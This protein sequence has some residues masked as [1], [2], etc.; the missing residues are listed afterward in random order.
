MVCGTGYWTSLLRVPRPLDSQ[1]LHVL[2]GCQDREVDALAE[3]IGLPTPQCRVS[4]TPALRV[5]AKELGKV[6]PW[7]R[8][9]VVARYKGAKRLRY[10]NAAATLDIRPLDSRDYKL[11]AFVKKEK[12]DEVKCPRLIQAR[13]ERYNIEFARYF[14]PIEHR[15][16]Q[17]EGGVFVGRPVLKGRNLVQRAE[18]IQQHWNE[19]NF[20]YCFDISKMD[21]SYTNNMFHML[22]KLYLK[23][24]RDPYFKRM[25]GKRRVSRG[26][27]VNGVRYKIYNKR[28]SGDIDTGGGNTLAV[29]LILMDFYR[30]VGERV[31]VSIDGD[32]GAAYFKQP[33]ITPELLVHQFKRFGF[34]LKIS[35][36]VTDIRDLVLCQHKVALYPKPHM[37]RNP[38]KALSQDLANV[39]YL[40]TEVDRRDWLYSLASGY[41]ELYKNVPVLAEWAQ[42]MSRSSQGGK[43]RPEY[44]DK[45]TYLRQSPGESPA[46]LDDEYRVQYALMWDLPVATQL[47]MEAALR[48]VYIDTSRQTWVNFAQPGFTQPELCDLSQIQVC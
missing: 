48:L 9:A 23:C 31:N 44:V 18:D 45:V 41:R 29:L 34:N 46:L 37:L 40:S 21:S 20:A 17:L 22:D 36:K 30:I 35:R 14:L 12:R 33:W 5:L 27:T 24:C 15:L 32:D 11:K 39:S 28:A 42:V 25:L 1:P 43:L 19:C 3:R 2:C 8:E 38:W 7:S 26:T 10:E 47:A 13:S 16:L 4:R 6:R